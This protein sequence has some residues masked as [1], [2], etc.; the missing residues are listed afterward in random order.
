VIEVFSLLFRWL[1]FKKFT[2][3]RASINRGYF[4]VEEE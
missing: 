1:V 3:T 2:H 4:G